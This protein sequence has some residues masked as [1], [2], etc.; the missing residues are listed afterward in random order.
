MDEL[1]KEERELLEK[2]N[3]V[4]EA[5]RNLARLKSELHELR[6]AFVNLDFVEDFSRRFLLRE[7]QQAE[8]TAERQAIQAESREKNMEDLL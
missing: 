3:E 6:L 5:K 4:L 7:Q 1:T 8:E 2:S